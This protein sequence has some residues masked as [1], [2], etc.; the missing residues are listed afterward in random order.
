MDAYIEKALAGDHEAFAALYD[1]YA[2]EALRFSA[3]VTGRG[4]LAADAVQEA[5]LRVYKKGSQCRGEFKPWFFRIVLNESYRLAKRNPY[6]AERTVEELQ[7]DFTG[8]SDLNITIHGALDSLK[9]EHRAVLV[10]R[11]LLDYSEK[12]MAQILNVPVGTVKSRV[13]YARHALAQKLRKE[14]LK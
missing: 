14:E 5:F 9:A 12:D 11:Y 10:L 1:R 3:A 2:P 13:F 8:Q 4:D 7:T 6:P